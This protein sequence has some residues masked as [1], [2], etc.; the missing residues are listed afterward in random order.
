MK[1]SV[2][3][4]AHNEE[5]LIGDCLNSILK[6]I[7]GKN[8]D[9]EIIVV[10][11]ASTDKTR[12][13]LNSFPQIRI[14]EEPKKGLVLARRAGYLASCGDLIANIDADN[15]VTEK[16][17]QKVFNEFSK[18][19]KLVGLSGPIIYYDLSKS[20]NL[21]VRTYYY[22]GFIIYL[23]NRH[24]LKIGSLLQGGNFVIK[25]T[26]LDAIGGFNLKYDFWGED[27]DL[28]RR[29]IAAGD[30]KFT[31]NL[32]IHSS[33]RRLKKDGVIKTGWLYM[34]NYLSTIFFKKPYETIARDFK[35]NL[36]KIK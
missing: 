4:P 10:D 17:F 7:D 5:K 11:N 12:E 2:V 1:L 19:N 27:A 34:I 14:I 22:L 13:I 35:D 30:V 3:I 32:P 31:F 33:G 25:K 18:N 28:A 24:L 8:Y 6:E 16:W 26:A 9:I 36:N 21:I 15:L 23:I 29:L 20:V